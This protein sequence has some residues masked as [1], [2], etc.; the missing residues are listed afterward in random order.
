MTVGPAAV[1]LWLWFIS[2][3]GLAV[4]VASGLVGDVGSSSV[5]TDSSALERKQQNNTTLEKVPYACVLIKKEK[6]GGQK[7]LNTKEKKT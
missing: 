5:F 4:W 2:A 6:K 7:I 1:V 3:E